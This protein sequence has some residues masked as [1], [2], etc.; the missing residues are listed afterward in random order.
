MELPGERDTLAVD[1]EKLRENWTRHRREVKEAFQ[2]VERRARRGAPFF[3]GARSYLEWRD[4]ARS[5]KRR[6]W[7]E[8]VSIS[9]EIGDVGV[10]RAHREGF[11]NL[12]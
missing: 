2:L 7:E 6:T 4:Y 11:R 9:R 1:R 10:N 5:G 12:I 8:V 3:S